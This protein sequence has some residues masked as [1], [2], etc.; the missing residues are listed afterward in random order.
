MEEY[1]LRTSTADGSAD[2]D[3]AFVQTEIATTKMKTSRKRKLFEHNLAKLLKL[4]DEKWREIQRRTGRCSALIKWTD[5]DLFMGHTTF[6]DFAEMTRIYKYYDFPLP[7]V[8]ASRIGFS[9]YPGV[10]GST[11]DFYLM[12]SGIAVTETTISMLS[13]APYDNIKDKE[14]RQKIPDYMRIMISN[15]LAHSGKE[16]TDYMTKSE[17]GTYSSQWIVL[18]YNL[19]Q[20]NMTKLANNTLWVLEQVPGKSHAEDMTPVLNERKYWA[21]YNRAWFPDVRA[22]MEA[23]V[24]EAGP[25]GSLFS[26]EESPRA[27]IFKAMQGK[28]KTL[29][30]MQDIMRS[31]NW[32]HEVDGGPNN[33]PD[34]AIAARSDWGERKYPFGAVDAKVTNFELSRTQEA[35]AISGPPAIGNHAPFRWNVTDRFKLIEHMGQPNEYNFPWVHMMVEE[36]LP[37]MRRKSA[38]SGGMPVQ[39]SSVPKPPPVASSKS[40]LT[41]LQGSSRTWSSNR[42]G[43]SSNNIKSGAHSGFQSNESRVLKPPQLLSKQ[44]A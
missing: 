40:F 27:H 10:A 12:N 24:A 33:T 14:V 31:N 39:S 13:D 2:D 25:S 16:W 44:K 28:V 15:R 8:A 35:L 17:T 3:P 9:S 21:S 43:L 36:G 41:Q 22:T 7:N 19:F 6:S 42:Q 18:D 5:N 38:S 37:L 1:L 23:T 30:D 4:N 20:A 26:R 34:H 11:D 32:P 29:Q